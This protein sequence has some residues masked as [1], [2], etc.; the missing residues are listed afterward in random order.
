MSFPFVVVRYGM[1]RGTVVPDCRRTRRPVPSQL[2][3]RASFIQV[4]Q[5]FKYRIRLGSVQTI[6]PNHHGLVD[7][8]AQQS[9]AE[10]HSLQSAFQPVTGWVRIRGWTRV[11]Y[12]PSASSSF[13]SLYLWAER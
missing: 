8:T 9:F 11:T 7:Y 2:N 5:V 1:Y 10:F 13:W 12:F 4:K 3:V 6:D